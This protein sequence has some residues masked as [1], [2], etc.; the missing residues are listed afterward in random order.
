M[1]SQEDADRRPMRDEAYWAA[2][3]A[4]VAAFPP[5]AL[6]PRPIWQ[7]DSDVGMDRRPQDEEAWQ[8]AQALLARDQSVDLLVTGYNQGGLLV[9]WQTLQ[10]FVPASQLRDF[11]LFHLPAERDRELERRVGQ[12]L[13]LKLIEVHPAKNRLVFSERAAQVAALS[14]EQLWAQLAAGQ[15]FGGMITNMT[16]FGAFV[17]LGGVEGLI[18]LSELSWRRINHPEDVVQPGQWVQTLVLQVDRSHER[19]ALS[20]KRMRPDPWQGVRERYQVG[21]IVAGTV[22]NIVPFGL[23]VTLE[24]ELEGLVHSSQLAPG[25]AQRL[26]QGQKVLVRVL[27]VDETG[28]RLALTLVDVQPPAP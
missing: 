6:A 11:P 13:T 1:V 26:T 8:A 14:R 16:R 23:F 20:L 12:R 5:E 3:L 9:V 18:H 19:I 15:V 25:T 22:S 17:D 21:E 24:E 10:G 4:Q 2:L 28:R 27:E 7:R